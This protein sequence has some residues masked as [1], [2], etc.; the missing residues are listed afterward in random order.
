MAATAT[1]IATPLGT[2]AVTKPL[3]LPAGTLLLL[4]PPDDAPGL[5]MPPLGRPGRLDK[6]WPALEATLAT[7]GQ[8]APELSAHLRTDF[9]AQSGERLAA[10]GAP[11]LVCRVR[12]PIAKARGLRQWLRGQ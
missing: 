3:A 8:A 2:L 12:C 1:L 5:A 7:L 10:V 9:S 11:L 4:V 6:G